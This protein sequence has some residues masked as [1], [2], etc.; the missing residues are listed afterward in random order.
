MRIRLS[1]PLLAGLWAA[2]PACQASVA[3]GSLE[4]AIVNGTNDPGDPSVVLVSAILGQLE[5]V[6]TGEVVS[7]HVVLTAA[8]CVDP[9]ILKQGSNFTGTPIFHVFTGYNYQAASNSQLLAVKATHYNPAFNDTTPDG[10]TQGNDIGVVILQNATS[11]APLVMNRTPIDNS[12]AGMPVRMVGY[13]VTSPSDTTGQTTGIRRQ[14]MVQLGG[15]WAANQAILEFSETTTGTCEGDSGGPAFMTLGGREV[16]AGITSFSTTPL[17]M[18]SGY[19]TRIDLF[20]DS[21]VKMYI[22]QADPGFVNG[23]SG[24]G[25]GGG[26]DG[27]TA[28]GPATGAV[29]AGCASNADCTSGICATQGTQ[30]YCTAPCDP[31]A[32]T[33]TCTGGTT[34]VSSSDGNYCTKQSHSGCQAAPGAPGSEMLL[35]F[36]ALVALLLRSSRRSARR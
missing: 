15:L 6:C 25:G 24:G 14:T 19:D 34:C 1:I 4:Q 2:L 26:S 17:C 5:S 22:D 11:L 3:A 8:H 32:A 10:P 20:A 7:P 35:F 31:N 23:G 36:A 12:M 29:G 28:G 21:W 9:T 18:S 13:G 33:D 16:I 30:R 27:G